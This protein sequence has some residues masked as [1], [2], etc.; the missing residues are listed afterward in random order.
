MIDH[1]V[2]AVPEDKFKECLDLY[3]K[4]FEPLGYQIAYQFGEYTAGL[5]SQLEP[6]KDYKLADL[7]VKGV[8]EGVTKTHLALRAKGKRSR[9]D[10]MTGYSP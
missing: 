8:K 7:W 1:T 3:V 6:I 5:G 4:A 2:I 10:S 9:V